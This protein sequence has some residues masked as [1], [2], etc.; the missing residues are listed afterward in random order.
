MSGATLNRIL[1]LGSHNLKSEIIGGYLQDTRL[2]RV[3]KAFREAN[4][5]AMVQTGRH[6]AMEDK[7]SV[8]GV[9]E[10]AKELF[11]NSN[12]EETLQRMFS[13]VS[14]K[15]DNL[16]VPAAGHSNAGF[17]MSVEKFGAL[18][19]RTLQETDP[20]VK[21]LRAERF[22]LF[23]DKIHKN[24]AKIPREVN[25][26]EPTELQAY[27]GHVQEL[28][29]ISNQFIVRERVAERF[30]QGFSSFASLHTSQKNAVAFSE[31]Q[32]VRFA[33]LEPHTFSLER[34]RKA[35]EI[36][37]DAEYEQDVALSQLWTDVRAIIHVGPAVNAKVKDIRA[38]LNDDLNRAT[39]EQ[40]HSLTCT[41]MNVCPPEI[42]KLHA[43]GHLALTHGR[44][45]SLPR[46]MVT[47]SNLNMLDL[48]NQH[49]R[50]IPE[51]IGRIPYLL[52]LHLANNQH[53]RTA[54]DNFGR[55]FMGIGTLVTDAFMDGLYAFNSVQLNNIDFVEWR[56]QHFFGARQQL[57][58]VPFCMWFRDQFSIPHFP[59]MV[60]MPVMIAG[61]VVLL[62]FVEAI[63]APLAAI[64]DWLYWPAKILV[65][66]LAY[67]PFAFVSGLFIFFEIPI[68]LW[69]LLAN[70]AIEPLV[71]A[72]RDQLGYKRM[73]H[74]DLPEPVV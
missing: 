30:K 6:L 34:F 49:F 40:V 61:L 22:I 5:E 47:L 26:A 35:E 10:S 56:D 18:Y 29:R 13:E 58:N 24:L 48:R 15:I 53:L 72:I 44:M 74:I 43:L 67:S 71:T 4:S 50:D 59:M 38:W 65:S 25:F 54:S 8:T 66:F 27:E 57:S 68:F 31:T 2:S 55:N 73:V 12:R 62:N 7:A 69:N 46:E 45:T 52:A 32:S 14:A 9:Q 64:S 23:I 39:L 17:R 51:V 70:L 28:I 33:Q 63:V 19:Q 11:G 60:A 20:Q 1:N 21:E 41:G 36:V 37:F 3:S 42:G 16:P